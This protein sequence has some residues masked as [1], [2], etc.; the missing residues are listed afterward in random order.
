MK[1]GRCMDSIYRVGAVNIA[2]EGMKKKKFTAR[3]DSWRELEGAIRKTG[4]I[5]S[6]LREV[7]KGNLRIRYVGEMLG[8]H[9]GAKDHRWNNTEAIC[10]N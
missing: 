7:R 2:E 4:N 8:R 1:N 5:C 6:E 10:S 9:T 3:E